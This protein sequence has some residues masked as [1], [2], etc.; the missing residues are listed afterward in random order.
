MTTAFDSSVIVAALASWHESHERARRAVARSLEGAQPPV[1]PDH[2][3]VEAFSVFTRLPPGYRISPRDAHDLLRAALH[4]RT[5]VSGE[6]RGAG[7]ALLGAAA[8]SDVA[9]GAVYD[10]R[11]L[12]AAMAAGATRLLTLNPS[13]F[14]RLEIEGVEIAEPE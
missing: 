11:I 12:R 5:R 9:G 4:R 10:L 14:E 8:A 6:R 13:D 1:V 3:L 7:W 2:A